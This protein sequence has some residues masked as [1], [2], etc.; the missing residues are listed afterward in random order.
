LYT[1]V[2]TSCRSRDHV[3]TTLL[4]SIATVAIVVHEI[5]I[6]RI[7]RRAVDSKGTLILAV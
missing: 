7:R 4:L 6:K 5:D 1:A 2:A 3:N